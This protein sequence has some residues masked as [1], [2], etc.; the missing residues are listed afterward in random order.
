M[1]RRRKDARPQRGPKE[2]HPRTVVASLRLSERLSGRLYRLG[3]P[4]SKPVQAHT[5]RRVL[6]TLTSRGALRIHAGYARAPDDVLAAIVRWASPRLRR[7]DR[8]AAQ[9]V[10]TAFPVHRHVPA[11]ALTARRVEPA[12][13]GDRRILRRL[14]ALYA[15]LNARHFGGRL[16]AVEFRISSRMRRRLGEFRPAEAGEGPEIALSRRHL[17][18]DR[19]AR[20][21]ETVLHEMV[22]QWQAQSGH[23]LG[24]GPDFRRKCAAVGIEG[25]AVATVRD[26]LRTYLQRRS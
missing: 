16:R 6:V 3:L 5:N 12:A 19:W 24:H 26:D 21:T 13:P 15:R 17:K 1:T 23:R 25:G 8:L 7:A 20:I 4:R 9:R 2:R 11:S 18:G 14:A 10:L 22:H